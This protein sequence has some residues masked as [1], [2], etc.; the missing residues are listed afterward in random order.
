MDR[1]HLPAL[2]L[3]Q[4]NRG[5]R[6]FALRHRPQQPVERRPPVRVYFF[7]RR[8]GHLGLMDGPQV[9]RRHSGVR[10]LRLALHHWPPPPQLAM[11]RR[12]PPVR[13]RRLSARKSASAFP[14]RGPERLVQRG[15]RL[16]RVPGQ[17]AS[18]SRKSYRKLLMA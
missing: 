15:L 8:L 7:L 9:D 17:S 13:L 5:G 12:P 3:L 2:L 11:E 10:P 18:V 4:V 6:P 1:L 14:T 16:T